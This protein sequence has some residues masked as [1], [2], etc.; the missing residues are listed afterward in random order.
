MENK[1]V[2]S[3]EFSILNLTSEDCEPE[4]TAPFFLD[5]NLLQIIDKLA[6]KWGKGV[7]THYMYL[8]G[9]REEEAYR[10]SVYG[11]IKKEAVYQALMRF[12]EKLAEVESLRGE[13]ERV[14]IPIQ[15][16]VWK[17]REVEAY[18]ST[19]DELEKELEA[20]GLSSE[21]MTGFLSILKEI[22]DDGGYRATLAK[23]HRLLEKMR[24][25]R[26]VLVYDKDRISVT[27]AE[28]TQNGGNYEEMLKRMGSGEIKQFL[29]PFRNDPGLTEL[30][31]ACLEILIDK[32]KDFFKELK[33]TAE[34]LAEYEKPVL[35]RFEQEITF[36]LSFRSLTKDME[37]KGFCFATPEKSD[38]N[39]MEAKGLYD[40]ALALNSLY[41][42]KKVVSNDFYYNEG[43]RFFVLTGPNQGGKTTFARSLG[44]LVY[45]SRIGLDVPAES[46]RLPFFPDIQTHFSVEESVETG[47]GKLKEELIRLA[48][49][50]SEY[51]KGTF[52]I[53]NELFTTAASYDATIMGK[54]VLEHFIELDCMGIYVTHLKELA[55][56]E[57]GVVSLRAMLNDQRIQTFRIMRGEAV[58]I[59][60]A[61]NQ[62]NK[63]RL[64]YEQLKERL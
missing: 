28:N 53:I 14:R 5:L 33:D 3:N 7:K 1:N 49:M 11:D 39:R 27:L 55:D 37:E 6:S 25:F 21:G 26:F 15:K 10:R 18:C 17:I 44:Q 32:D 13:N 20:A 58:D 48:P 38:D 4:R 60:C 56:L 42:G 29:N 47:R 41:T 23:T 34:E 52:V 45:F 12:T 22:L 64:T 9:S 50:M 63:Y 35:K 2:K 43:E 40:L 16:A 59:P 31:K 51:R 62:V 54:K 57:G 36:Y 61:E 30:E 8:P 19:Y 24:N 46:A